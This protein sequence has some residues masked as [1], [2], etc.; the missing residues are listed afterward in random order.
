M[1]YLRYPIIVLCLIVV[2]CGKKTQP[3]DEGTGPA[4]DV[5]TSKPDNYPDDPELT[6]Q[7]TLLD[8]T[9]FGIRGELHAPSN[10]R[11]ES[12]TTAVVLKAGS[13]FAIAVT[14]TK[15]TLA[16]IKAAWQPHV[17]A[18]VNEEADV[19]VAESD[20]GQRFAYLAPL[21]DH[22]VLLH[23]PAAFPQTATQVQRAL[24]VAKTIVQTDVQRESLRREAAL[25]QALPKM[26]CTLHLG[27]VVRE[28]DIRGELV[29]DDD[30]A[31]LKDIAGLTKVTLTGPANVTEK[32]YAHI[33][34]CRG[35]RTLLLA[36]PGLTPEKVAP[37]AKLTTLEELSIT[38]H[39]LNDAGL[40]FLSNLKQ[41]KTLA[42]TGPVQDT[43]ITVAG[44]AHLKGLKLDTLQLS[45][46][47]TTEAMLEQI[48][49]MRGLK[50][51][52]VSNSRMGEAGTIH[53]QRLVNL[54]TL[55]LNHC[56]VGD[57]GMQYLS[58][59]TKLKELGLH[60]T[61]LRGYGL[62]SLAPLS[63]LKVLHLNDTPLGDTA[64]DKI[65]DLK[66]E[67]LD[68]SRTNVG[69]AG[70]KVLGGQTELR[71]LA[72]SG[73]RIT[74][75]GLPQLAP[76]V[77]LQSLRVNNTDITGATLPALHGWTH[78][79]QL[80]LED[81]LV[82]PEALARLVAFKEL[83]E[84]NV[85]HS[86]VT[87]AGLL[88]LVDTAI[89]KWNLAETDVSATL[90]AKLRAAQ[91][92]RQIVWTEPQ[93]IPDPKPVVPPMEVAALPPADPTALLNKF[94]GKL[95]HQE[96]N[97]E[98]P[99]RVVL[100]SKDVTDV[101]IAHLRGVKNLGFLYLNGCS[102]LTDACLPYLALLP[103]LEELYLNNTAITGDGLVHLKGLT[104][105][106]ELEIG[107]AT[108]TIKQA[109]PLTALKGLTHL[110]L[111]VTGDADPVLKFYTSFRRLKNLDLSA[112]S[113]NN[114][115]LIYLKS[116]PNLEQLT[117]HSNLLGD[118]G[119]AHLKELT[120][121]QDLHLQSD[122]LSDAGF[123]HLEELKSLKGLVLNTPQ[124]TDTGFR[125]L[126]KASELETLRVISARITNRGMASVRNCAKLREL[127][128]RG[129]DIGDAGIAHL[130][131]LTE[132]ELIDLSQ[133]KVTD[134]G[135]KVLHNKK[136]LRKL[137]LNE[138]AVTGTGFA[139]LKELK[140]LN[141]VYL[142]R[143]AFNDAGAAVLAE[144]AEDELE[145]LHVEETA[146][147]DAGIAALKRIP[148]LKTLVANKNKG[149]SDKAIATLKTFP[150]LREIQ[151][152]DTAVTNEGL[153]TLKKVDG[154]KINED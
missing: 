35:I 87:D 95:S 32:G 128:M 152:R 12:Y 103:D 114:R 50:H 120:K 68:L 133:T 31:N 15:Q 112:L 38:N 94:G 37:L 119:L 24:D 16:E 138:T 129:A 140:Y 64:P 72:L 153:S 75:A 4:T 47:R 67:E 107:S 53:L 52:D 22:K 7:R 99:M 76:L 11:V 86:P 10:A 55:A 26:G 41:L 58:G 81:T 109:A 5:P 108:V 79:R 45:G 105:L 59:M 39:Q 49:N 65:K 142:N 139:P 9:P 151:L 30:L 25:V 134:K 102:K 150:D 82:T 93:T 36:G 84:L 149:I 34:A 147:T 137:L 124:L 17:K 136:E 48:G 56:N 83:A 1:D 125:F 14:P 61:A 71:R 111:K 43:G 122:L 69:D 91:P 44:I 27:E 62:S 28:L 116:V 40:A 126:E 97:P 20:V 132:L 42:F 46:L 130:E 121:L 78:L 74:D 6:T 113:I 110:K 60:H 29:T 101:D 70:L 54:E 144:I 90:V 146:L 73:T 92:Q 18:F 19:L 85:A 51:L 63:N 96:N 104:N 23:T 98:K 2:S 8:L 117:L 135:L 141:R 145:V 66:L 131:N 3:S 100:A 21:G 80:E 13:T 143:T 57:L 154:L 115:R 123:K 148:H 33:A 106:R 127:E 89:H 118:R 88:P 77:Q